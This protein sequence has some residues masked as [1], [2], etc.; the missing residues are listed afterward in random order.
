MEAL[1]DDV[2]CLERTWTKM[3]LNS[4]DLI[5]EVQAQLRSALAALPDPPDRNCPVGA[6]VR[7]RFDEI[8]GEEGAFWFEGYLVEHRAD[9]KFLC[10]FEDGYSDWY[11]LEDD[12]LTV[13][14]V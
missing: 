1:V 9:G 13:L 7:V 11:G 14:G 3:Q 12:G 2:A 4:S 8:D 6:R 10:V 5:A